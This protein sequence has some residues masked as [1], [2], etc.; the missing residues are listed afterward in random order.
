MP[1]IDGML[2]CYFCPWAMAAIVS[3]SIETIQ[4][5]CQPSTTPSAAAHKADPGGTV[6][7]GTCL[8]TQGTSPHQPQ[9][10]QNVAIPALQWDTK[11]F[12]MPH[13]SFSGP[14]IYQGWWSLPVRPQKLEKRAGFGA[15]GIPSSPATA[16]QTAMEDQVLVQVASDGTGRGPGAIAALGSP[17]L[18]SMPIIG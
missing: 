10:L 13:R 2:Q 14:R 18:H 11:S 15:P 6:R 1:S 4:S 8:Q 9:P 17:V 5:L 3:N 7:P 12:W 16:Y